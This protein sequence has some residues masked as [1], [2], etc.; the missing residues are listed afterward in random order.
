VRPDCDEELVRRGWVAACERCG[1][2]LTTS[3]LGLALCFPATRDLRARRARARALPPQHV[4]RDGRPTLVVGLWDEASGDRVEVLFDDVTSRGGR[5]RRVALIGV[6]RHRDFALLWWG[7]LV[8]VAGDWL[9]V[10]VLPY[11]VY[12]RTGSTIA[13]AGMT[14]AEL[15]PGILLG[16][17]AGVL[18]DRW[19]RQRVLVATNLLQAAVVLALLLVSGTSLLWVVYLVAAAQ[20]ALSAFAMPAENSLLPTLVPEEELVPANA[21]NALNNRIGRLSGLPLGPVVY[22]VGGLGAVAAADALTFLVAAALV[23][24][25]SARRVVPEGEALRPPATFLAEWRAGLRLVRRDRSVAV[26][27]V[28]FGLM[29]FGGTML[30]PLAAPWVRD[31]LG[32]GD[33]VYALLM[34]VHAMAGIAGSLVVGACGARLSPRLL[35]GGGSALAGCLLL[36][37]FN[38]PVVAVA[39]VLSLLSGV[40]AVSSSVGVDTLTQQRVPD[41]Y[42]GRVFGTLQAVVW[43]CSLLGAVVSGVTAARLGLLVALDLA[44]GLVLLAGVVVLVMLPARA[45]TEDPR[46]VG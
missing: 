20:S 38:V 22:A 6:L 36:V 46:P 45:R 41:A 23:S 21:L 32:R 2:T 29:T 31:V 3:L 7:G 35:C 28:V 12:V 13:T 27:F 37:R 25:M 39:V 43:T 10:A 24:L 1:E 4:D 5:P 33:D 30:D 14:V 11:V 8:S 26:L 44:S 17:L 15:L 18:V 40:T 42:R 9:L 19:D 16:S 34:T